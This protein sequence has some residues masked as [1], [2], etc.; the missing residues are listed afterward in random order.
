M[1]EISVNG[2]RLH[3]TERGTGGTTVVFAHGMLFSGEMFAAQVAALEDDYRCIT[4]DFRGQ[5]RSEVTRN[6]YDMDTLAGDAAALIEAL[7]A[8]PC[9]FCG[10]SMGGFVAMRLAIERPE[11]IRSLT[12]MGTS[13]DPESRKSLPRYRL[14]RLAGRCFGFGVVVDRIM[15]ILFGRKFLDDP[16]RADLCKELRARV[17]AN[18][19]V[20]A[21]RAAAGVFTRAGVHDRLPRITCPTLVIVGD[22]DV[23]TVPAKA[24]RIHRQIAG[25]KLVVIPGAGHTSCIEESEAVT[26]AL[27]EFLVETDSALRKPPR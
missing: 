1:P 14:M 24:E 6:G 5:G 27:R 3:Y 18:D 8:G 4:F 23:A 7:D 20:G 9:H 17:V 16:S 25:S 21:S 26:A 10:L 22:Q 19:R 11:L 13:A 12:L 15:P 2:A